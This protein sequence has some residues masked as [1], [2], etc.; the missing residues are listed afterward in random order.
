MQQEK[1]DFS[2]GRVSVSG[3]PS[4]PWP[5]AWLFKEGI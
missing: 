3:G 4:V 2:A 1:N 5:T